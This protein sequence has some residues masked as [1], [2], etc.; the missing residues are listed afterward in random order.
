MK[1]ILKKKYGLILLKM[2]KESKYNKFFIAG[3]I[4]G[5]ASLISIYPFEFIKTQIQL[6]ENKGLSSQELIKKTYKSSGL[7]G[8]YKGLNNLLYF[9]LLRHS[10]SFYLF[11]KNKQVFNK[12][13]NNVYLINSISSVFSSIITTT[14]FGLPGENLKVYS[15]KQTN[16]INKLNKNDFSFIK[17]NKNFFKLNGLTGYYKGGINGILK[18]S[19]SQSFKIGI[20]FNFDT[21]YLSNIKKNIEYKKTLVESAVLGGISGT[22][23]TII[24]NP[25]DVVQTR[26]QSDYNKKYT[27]IIDCY[28]QIYNEEGIKAFTKGLNYRIIRTF[29]GMAIYMTVFEQV[30]NCF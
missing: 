26:L 18:D 8:F 10:F 19:I 27:S 20:Y 23:G 4:A 25:I 22:I 13:F 17:T 16:S 14:I 12:Y 9:S 15:I 6:I 29:P 1:Q 3:A 28:K 5:P 7:T 30:K 24:N 2:N 11:D 21:F